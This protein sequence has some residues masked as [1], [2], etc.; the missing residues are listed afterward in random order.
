MIRRP[1]HRPMRNWAARIHESSL[2]GFATVVLENRYLRLTVLVD[3]GADL[4]E[5]N[6]KPHD[7]DFVWWAADGLPPAAGN[8]SPDPAA[9]FF[10]WY[11]GGWQEIFPNGGAPSRHRGAPFA[12]HGDLASQAWDYA[13]ADDT[14]DAVAVTFTARSRGVPARVSKTLRLAGGQPCFSVNSQ[15]TNESDVPVEAMWGQHITFGQPFLR[16]GCTLLLPPGLRVL[17]HPEAINPP[18]RRV[19]HRGEPYPWPAVTSPDGEGVDLSILPA[20]GTPSEMLYL[21]GFADGWYELADPGT[22]RGL[23]LD[24]DARVL[25][26]LW[27]WQEFGGTVDYPWYGRNYNIGLEPF[28]SYPTNGL[29]EAVRNRTALTLAPHQTRDLAMRIQVLDEAPGGGEPE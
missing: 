2:G 28:S 25:P 27:F 13:I 15:L 18:R 11:E 9:A 3:K 6:Y 22:G 4:V 8:G 12:Q 26:Y 1:I 17:T 14:A 21:T 19:A 10:G 29:A 24:W 20:A 16:P 5:L 7:L 23:R